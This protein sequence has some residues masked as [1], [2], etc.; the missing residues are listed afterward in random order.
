M[1]LGPKWGKNGPKMAKNGIWGHFSIFSPFLG[2]FFPFRPEGHFYFLANFFPF[3]DLGP[4][5]ILYQAA[6]LAIPSSIND[7][8]PRGIVK[9]SGFTR[10]A[11]YH[12][13]REHYR[14]N[15]DTAEAHEQAQR[16]GWSPPLKATCQYAAPPFL[17]SFSSWFPPLHGLCPR[18]LH[19]KTLPN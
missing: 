7:V 11:V 12:Y 8:Q 5:S 19:K 17:P 4:F 14:I 9:A 10:G 6:W 16:A 13:T 18:P 3:L 1:A 2:H 15:S